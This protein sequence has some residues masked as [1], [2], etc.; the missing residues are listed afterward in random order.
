MR[1]SKTVKQAMA[2]VERWNGS[3]GPGRKWLGPKA[4]DSYGAESNRAQTY[5]LEGSP[6]RGFVIVTDQLAIAISGGG[7]KKKA[8][9]RWREQFASH[10]D[11]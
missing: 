1:V 3:D 7:D 9:N 10:D 6:P 11:A 4:I 8:L 5:V 2:Q